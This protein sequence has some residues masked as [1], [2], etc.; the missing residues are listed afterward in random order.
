MS[1]N[2]SGLFRQL[3]I[4][5]PVSQTSAGSNTVSLENSAGGASSGSGLS[6][7]Q[8]ML[9]G[10]T[11]S[12]QII[13]TGENT[14]LMQLAD[15][16]TFS[17]RLA[18]GSAVSPGQ[19]LTFM[20]Q[21]NIENMITLK[22]LMA[23]EQQAVLIEKALDAASF[24][25]TDA[26][27]NIVKELLN[28]NMPVS[29]EVISD[30]VKN[31]M[32]F[33]ETSLNTIASLMKLNM[34]VTAENV[35]QFE[36]YQHYEHSILK[37]LGNVE[38]DLS[39][40]LS[41]LGGEQAGSGLSMSAGGLNF[42]GELLQALYHT[43]A[44]E[45]H[46]MPDSARLNTFMNEGV[47]TSLSEQIADTFSG[48]AGPDGAN[49]PSA[50]LPQEVL[51]LVRDTKEG[52]LTLEQLLSRLTEQLQAHPE[53]HKQMGKLFRSGEMNGLLQ[54]MVNETLKLTPADVANPEGIKNYYKRVRGAL[55][56][57]EEAAGK[58]GAAVSLGK[59]MASIKSNIDF[60]NDL[61]RNMTFFQMPVHFSESD[62]NGE[63]YVFT[64]K[65][66]LQN[67]PDQV[68][69][70]LHLDMDHLGPMDIYVKLAGKNVSTNFCL[71]S[72]E[73]LDFVYANID[74]LNRRLEALGYT[75]KFEMK[76]TE[77]AQQFDFM[78]DFVQKDQSGISTS[79]YIFDIKA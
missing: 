74:R 30:M 52:G 10:E 25:A 5:A 13:G 53:A 48:T 40:F 56:R 20:V 43:P 60:M 39:L 38:Q 49:A 66:A 12:G 75:A 70:L 69:A 54:Q 22:P 35:M 2:L 11:F 26:N 57:A 79:Q 41:G 73:M 23:S 42:F 6:Q 59:E 9:A 47:L 27:I 68:S 3:N 18:D 61:N 51:E 50:G 7:L 62:A 1:F 78:E 37:E 67:N 55:E 34:P 71:E 4:Q 76:V 33:P 63:L 64:N 21:E 16:S 46:Q 36:A 77:P 15:G 24:P 72:G 8:N 32:R 17:A 65:K 45:A 44:G 14:V 28:Q 31:S 19:N 29:A 58:E